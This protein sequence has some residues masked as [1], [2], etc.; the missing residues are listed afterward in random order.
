MRSTL[1]CRPLD[2]PLGELTAASFGVEA[3]HEAVVVDRVDRTAGLDDVRARAGG[4]RNV[5]GDGDRLVEGVVCAR[6]VPGRGALVIPLPQPGVH[7]G[8]PSR[9]GLVVW[10]VPVAD[11]LAEQRLDLPAVVRLPGL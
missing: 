11:V 8:I 6:L 2:V 5:T 4:D 9:D 7:H 10:V 3:D 1:R